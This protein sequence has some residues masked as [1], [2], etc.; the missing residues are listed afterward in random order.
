M[1]LPKPNK[2]EKKNDFMKRCVKTLA[3][4]DDGKRWKDN[5]QRVAVCYDCW[6][7]EHP[8]DLIEK[9]TKEENETI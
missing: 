5:K 7:K 1:P 3:H 8:E 6:R 4:E 9:Y 2:K